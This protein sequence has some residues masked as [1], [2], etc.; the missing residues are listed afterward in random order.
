MQRRGLKPHPWATSAG[1][2]SSALYNFINGDS[3]SLSGDTLLKLAKAAGASVEELMGE[4]SAKTSEA[5]GTTVRVP[6]FVST[7]GRLVEAERAETVPYPIGVLPDLALLC[8]RVK[9][10]GPSFTAGSLVYF[11]EKSRSPKDLI[12][13]LVIAHTAHGSNTAVRR[14]GRGSS[15]GLYTLWSSDSGLE[16]GVEVESVQFIVATIQPL[17]PSV[18]TKK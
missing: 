16:E 3:H 9:K 13:F 2:R 18:L 10:D 4:P 1:I 15:A 8:A 6:Y 17:P 11:E 12:G 5:L 14:L 7:L